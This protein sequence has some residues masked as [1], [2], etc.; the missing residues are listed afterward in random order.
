MIQRLLALGSMASSIWTEVLMRPSRSVLRRTR[1]FGFLLLGG[2]ACGRDTPPTGYSARRAALALHASTVTSLADGTIAIAVSYRQEGEQLVP[3]VANPSSIPLVRG[4]TTRQPVEVDLAPCL[5]DS[6][7]KGAE[8]PG[9][10]LVVE[11]SLRDASGGVIDR[12]QAS[13]T[14]R[15]MPGQVAEMPP[16]ALTEVGSVTIASPNSARLEPGGKVQLTA[17]VRTPNGSTIAGYPVSW[18]TSSAAVATV[19]AAT[20]EVTA[21][22]AGSVTITA[23]AGVK[24]D[25]AALTVIAPASLTEIAPDNSTVVLDHLNG[26]TTGAAS[27]NLGFSQSQLGLG[28][29]AQLSPGAYARYTVVPQLEA[30]GTVEFWLNPNS[31]DVGLLNFNWANTSSYPPAGHVLHVFLNAAGQVEIGGW[32]QDPACMYSLASSSQLPLKRWTH[33]A[34]SWGA[35]T[36]IYVNGSVSVSSS[37]CFLPARPAFAYLHYWGTGDLGAI[38]ELHISSVQRSDAEIARHAGK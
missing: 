4:T 2:A 16:V 7:R 29:A 28:R 3:L 34:I 26:A 23:T 8:T 24:S 20:G 32:A 30:Q 35:L 1:L 10:P 22:A 15:A 13:P 5:A 36:K 14:T 6:K 21:V 38:D 9:C 27:G 33:V 31:Y 19:N 11:L 17:T 12:Q 18:S 25:Q 37:Q